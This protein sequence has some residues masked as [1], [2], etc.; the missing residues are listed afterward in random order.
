MFGKCES[1]WQ[2]DETTIVEFHKIHHSES[3]TEG[4]D[5]EL[6]LLMLELLGEGLAA[7]LLTQ[8]FIGPE[9]TLIYLVM[10]RAD[11]AI[12]DDVKGGDQL[13]LTSRLPNILEEEPWFGAEA[14]A[15]LFVSL[16]TDS[17]FK[18]LAIIYVATYGSIPQS[19]SNIFLHGALLQIKA[20]LQIGNVQVYYWMKCH[21]STVTISTGDTAYDITFVV[22]ERK[23]FA[24]VF[25]FG[26]KKF[27]HTKNGVQMISFFWPQR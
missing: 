21:R 24:L 1:I 7:Q 12:I 3:Q 16:T 11:L 26:V 14:Q 13:A 8:L 17:L 18:A 20:T 15:Q 10:V 9:T 19:G 6:E 4:T 23:Q 25:L 27:Y 22:D 2:K 5:K